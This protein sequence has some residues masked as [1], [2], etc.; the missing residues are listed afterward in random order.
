MGVITGG[1]EP[2]DYILSVLYTIG[3]GVAVCR[4][5]M[6]IIGEKSMI[7]IINEFEEIYQV[8]E[9]TPDISEAIDGGVMSAIRW[10]ADSGSFEEYDGENWNQ[11]ESM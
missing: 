11:V 8:N 1:S 9:L 4:S 6:G 7:L 3:A 5:G 2:L 10:S